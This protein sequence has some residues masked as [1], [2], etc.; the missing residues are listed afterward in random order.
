MAQNS[1]F[2]GDLRRLRERC[3]YDLKYLCAVK[4]FDENP[5]SVDLDNMFACYEL[6]ERRSVTNQLSH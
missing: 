2:L 5:S 3:A 4:F 1:P 6:V